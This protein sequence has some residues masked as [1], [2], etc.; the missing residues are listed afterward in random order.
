[1]TCENFELKILKPWLQKLPFI[2]RVRYTVELCDKTL[3]RLDDEANFRFQ[4]FM[5]EMAKIKL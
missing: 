5:V 2:A 1:M 3:Y 4:N